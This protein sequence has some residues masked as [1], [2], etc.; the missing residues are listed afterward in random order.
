MDGDPAVEPQLDGFSRILPLPYRVALIIVLGTSTVH[1]ISSPLHLLTHHRHLGMGPQ[2]PLPLPHKNRRPLPHPLSVSL[3]T[4]PPS[5]PPLLLPHRNLPLHPARPLPPALLD[6]N[7]RLPP[8]HRKLAD[9][10]QSLPPRSGHRLHRAHTFRLTQRTQPHA[11]DAQ[12]HQHR[13]HR[14]GRGRQIRRYLARG[15]VDELCESTRRF[16][17]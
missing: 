3:L 11:R 9:P 4:T 14:R 10:T 2:P 13:R 16:V 1:P 5:S 12:A 17:C 6:Y 7:P 15:C 8:R